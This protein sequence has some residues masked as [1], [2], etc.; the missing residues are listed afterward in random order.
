M[1][2]S[3]RESFLARLHKPLGRTATIKDIPMPP[4]VDESIARLVEP[5]ADL[6]AIFCKTAAATGM[7]IH[8]VTQATLHE[9]M[10][11]RLREENVR[12]LGISME[13]GQALTD[14]VKQGGFEIFDWQANPGL[15]NQFDLEA[16]ITDVHGAIAE[17]GSMICESSA[18]HTRGLSLIV[19]WHLAVVKKS[20]IMPDLIDFWNDRSSLSS[21]EM[22][23]SIA[24][25]TG[26]SKTADIE[27][28]LITGV[29]GPAKV[30]VFVVEDL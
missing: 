24:I 2:R 8:Q 19:P 7:T 14:A 25:I 29:H 28:V 17:T 3:T 16:G 6:F 27:G 10:T 4:E 20:Q 18:N 15:G 12:K 11:A 26:P 9:K 23:S 1:A 5:D 30:D 22:P 13:Q 21:Q